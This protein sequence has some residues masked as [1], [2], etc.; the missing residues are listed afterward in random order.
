MPRI[1]YVDGRYVPHAQAQV[2][3]EDR[4]FQFADSIYE[5]IAVIDGVFADAKGHLDRLERSAAELRLSL[6]SARKAM[7]A[8]MRELL[9]RNRLRNAS[10]YI[11]VTRGTAARDFPFPKTAVRPTLVMT[12]RPANYDMQKR[13]AAV[14]KIVTVPDI[15]WARRDIKSTA[16]LAQVLLRQIAVDEGADEAW[17]VDEDG[18]ITEGAACNAWIIDAKKRL[19]TRPAKGNRILKGVTRSALQELCRKEGLT[20]VERA[21]SVKEARAAKEAFC[22]SA[23]A[24]IAPVSHIDGRKIGTG[25]VGAVTEKIMDMYMTYAANPKSRQFAW[26]EK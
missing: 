15:R 24:M 14:K 13:K 17:L 26:N 18:M 5:V 25:K 20:L 2:H 10:L 7:Q 3:I 23:V 22:S 19:I 21:F 16:L 8:V 12:L 1:A 6:P 4:G 11:Q 9:R